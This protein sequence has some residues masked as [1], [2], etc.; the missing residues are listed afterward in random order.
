MK[1]IIWLVLAV[2]I[3]A[4][5]GVYMSLVG[6]KKLET[7]LTNLTQR[8][9]DEIQKIN[10]RVPPYVFTG[11]EVGY[12]VEFENG[13]KFYISGDTTAMADMEFVIGDYYN[14]DV[15]FRRR[16]IEMDIFPDRAA[17]D[18]NVF[19]VLSLISHEPATYLWRNL[20]E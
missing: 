6:S 3:I 4:L 2:L 17:W 1:K 13:V 9:E 20:W 12:V 18:R 11:S 10:N 5:M 14:P 16:S 15:A 8:L 19:Q 7:N